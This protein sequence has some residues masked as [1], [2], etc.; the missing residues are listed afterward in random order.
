MRIS[1]VRLGTLS[2]RVTVKGSISCGYTGTRYGEYGAGREREVSQVH[3]GE[4]LARSSC[5]GLARVLFVL[6]VSIA[7]LLEVV[8]YGMIRR[9]GSMTKYRRR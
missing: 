4:V 3:G 2:G 1:S 9:R 6:V 8:S 5:A 7:N